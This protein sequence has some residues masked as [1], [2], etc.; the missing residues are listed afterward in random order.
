MWVKSSVRAVEDWWFETTRSV[1]TSGNEHTPKSS[2]IM[3]E[4]RDGNIYGP[5]RVANARKALHDLP[6]DDYS[7]YTFIDIG[8]GK[9]RALFVA[10]ELPFQK[11]LG[12]EYSVDLHEI[13]QENIRR[14]S[15]IRQKCRAIESVY[16]NAADFEFPNQKLV[17]YLF[18]PF[19]P[20]VM[21]HMLAN[22]ERSLEKDPRHVV[23]VML[24]PEQSQIVARMPWMHVYKQTRQYHIYQTSLPD[25]K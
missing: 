10:A 7:G 13:A 12:I 11:V 19:G 9:G 1:Q 16:A 4:L 3:G 25:G 23:M 6:I 8:S 14:W 24:W 20:D 22:L 18:N 15:H 2:K 5:V 17:L 21:N